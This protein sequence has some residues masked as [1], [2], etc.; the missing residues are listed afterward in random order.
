[1]SIDI[2]HRR[3]GNIRKVTF[4]PKGK[5]GFSFNMLS[6]VALIFIAVGY[7]GTVLA[8]ILPF[9]VM[10]AA[11]F[12][13]QAAYPLVASLTAQCYFL[14][15]NRRKQALFLGL[16][17]AVAHIPTMFL[18]IGRISLLCETSLLFPI[19]MGYIGLMLSDM[20]NLDRNV[21]IILTFL[22]CFS[23]SIGEGG[24]AVVVWT[25]IFGSRT[26]SITKTKL[27]YAVGLTLVVINLI[28]TFMAGFGNW[29]GIII[30][31]GFLLAAPFLSK[32]NSFNAD[33]S[34]SHIFVIIYPVMIAV[35]A[36]I[37]TLRF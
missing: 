32:Y 34:K 8:D 27:F 13:K 23:A 16:M 29:T 7:T 28:Y 37:V 35:Y 31:L 14:A 24:S 10:I 4:S 17:T 1:M 12:I 26:D 6:A 33:A 2:S 21:K 25:L 22:I 20:P 11:D 19:F 36:V 3:S 5:K 9:P 18:S 15:K 30:S